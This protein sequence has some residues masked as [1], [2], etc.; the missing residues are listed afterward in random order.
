MLKYKGTFMKTNIING[1]AVFSL[2]LL[3][4]QVIRAQGTLTYLSNLGQASTGGS[5]VGSNS[6]LAT[7]F[8]TGTNTAGYVLDSV[9][10]AMLDALLNPTGFTAM[11]YA[12]PAGAA[13]RPGFSLATLSG[14]LNP[15][16]AGTYT[17]TAPSNL[18]LR[19]NFQ[20]F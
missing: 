12:P 15:A 14:S 18:T 17:Y 1:V 13:P 7:A 10:L 16:T 19:P 4:P 2:W 20:Y 5:P 8:I 9:Q 11:L 3:S 6:W